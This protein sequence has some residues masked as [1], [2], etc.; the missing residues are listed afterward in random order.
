MAGISSR[1]ILAFIW[2]NYE[3]YSCAF[4]A[5]SVS[6]FVITYSGEEVLNG[7]GIED[8]IFNSAEIEADG[9]SIN[10]RVKL[11]DKL[12][13]WYIF[14]KLYPKEA[15]SVDITV[16]AH[17]DTSLNIGMSRVLVVRIDIPEKLLLGISV[18]NTS[19]G[20]TCVEYFSS[21]LSTFHQVDI[22]DSLTLSRLHDKYLYIN[23]I[24]SRCNSWDTLFSYLLFDTIAIS[25]SN[26]D[27]FRKLAEKVYVD[28]VITN[29]TTQEEVEALLF[30]AAGLLMTDDTDDEYLLKLKAIY[31]DIRQKYNIIE[32]ERSDWYF[33][34]RG[35]NITIHVIIARLAAL[36][37]AKISF[38]NILSQEGRIK[39]IY[40]V[41]RRELSPYWKNRTSFS[42]HIV[43]LSG[44]PVLSDEKIDIFIINVIIPL[45]YSMH[46]S[47]GDIPSDVLDRMIDM[48]CKIKGEKNVITK[49]WSSEGFKIRSA[50][51]SQAIIHLEKNYC[52]KNNCCR[53]ILFSRMV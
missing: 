3:K 9:K 1:K 39:N 16:V 15:E 52:K 48:L 24:Y 25:T 22:L 23:N 51:D 30:G 11:F 33:N 42:R 35:Y 14:E 44:E 47:L 19:M 27:N 53:C 10:G 49:K 17:I 20:T 13:E 21:K 40:K 38:V 2:R 7:V 32:M 34:Y 45:T 8:D 4:K 18:V 29:L 31:I 5:I 37:H 36:L 43:K 6:D 41:M 46:R 12:S 26:R 28:A 50:F